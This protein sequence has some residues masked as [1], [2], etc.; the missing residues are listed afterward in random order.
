MCLGPTQAT[1]A[2]TKTAIHTKYL[3]I[4]LK[5]TE[6]TKVSSDGSGDAQ[7]PKEATPQVF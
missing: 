7:G 3:N 2:Q 1:I 5:T 4:P 6:K